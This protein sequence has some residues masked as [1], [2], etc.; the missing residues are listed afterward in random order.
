LC[1]SVIFGAG[2]DVV[3]HGSVLRG[4]DHV[5]DDG[6]SA[7]GQARLAE[8][9][10]CDGT[11]RGGQDCRDADTKSYRSVHRSSPTAAFIGHACEVA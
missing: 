8:T 7:I 1:G 2:D 6:G 3:D 10:E 11:G 5:K 9:F 4:F